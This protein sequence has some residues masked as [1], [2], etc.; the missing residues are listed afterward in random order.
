MTDKIHEPEILGGY[1]VDTT[2]KLLEEGL[3]ELD[4]QLVRVIT[5]SPQVSLKT[6]HIA[7]LK[8]LPTERGPAD[9]ASA[10]QDAASILRDLYITSEKGYLNNAIRKDPN[11]YF[12]R[13]AERWELRG[14]ETSDGLLE[15]M[16]TE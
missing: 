10:R 14:Y 15:K 1:Q 12:I 16:K 8:N 6:K 3:K 5:E 9:R 11:N 13:L 4:R 7:T 2:D